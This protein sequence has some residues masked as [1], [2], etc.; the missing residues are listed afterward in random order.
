MKK[1]FS[2]LWVTC[3]AFASPDSSHAAVGG[4][5]R[6]SGPGVLGTVDETALSL[7]DT[8]SKNVSTAAHGFM[9][10]LSGDSTTFFNGGGTWSFPFDSVLIGPV[11][12]SLAKESFSVVGW[13]IFPSLIYDDGASVSIH[14]HTT[15]SVETLQVTNS[16]TANDLVVT[17]FS[18]VTT[19]NATSGHHGLLPKVDGDAN[20][21]LR[22]DGTFGTVPG[23]ASSGNVSRDPT[24]TFPESFNVSVFT[25]ALQIQSTAVQVT[26]A[27]TDSL[28]MPGTLQTDGGLSVGGGEYVRKISH[29]NFTWP[30]GS[31]GHLTPAYRDVSVPGIK[32]GDAVTL[33]IPNDISTTV[34]SP[35]YAQ[36]QTFVDEPTEK[37]RVCFIYFASTGMTWS[38]FDF[39]LT[40]LHF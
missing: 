40:V 4:G 22:G 23:A 27:G 30:G 24:D 5:F 31:I 25:S 20:H 12:N 33:S 3:L 19:G 11:D 28:Y 29:L 7:H 10:K 21:V 16:I 32:K 8:I 15:L 36:W 34:G 1:I 26:G 35:L 9:P 6:G 2:L 17:N 39:T 14:G 38:A 13:K 18:D 37:V